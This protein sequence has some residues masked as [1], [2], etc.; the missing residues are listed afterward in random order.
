MLFAFEVFLH[1]AQRFAEPLE[2]HDLSLPQE[3]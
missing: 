1:P 2:V 3:F